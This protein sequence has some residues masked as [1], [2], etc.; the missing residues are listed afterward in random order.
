MKCNWYKDCMIKDCLH[1]EEHRELRFACRAWYCGRK[2][3]VAFCSASGG[4]DGEMNSRDR[5][6]RAAHTT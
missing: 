2:R 5:K 4:A 1:K 3:D 6:V